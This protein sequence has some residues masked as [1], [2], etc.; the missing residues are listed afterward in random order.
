MIRSELKT[1]ENSRI[2][3]A[4]IVLGVILI[5]QPL[6]SPVLNGQSNYGFA[7]IL[8]RN[9]VEINCTSAMVYWLGSNLSYERFLTAWDYQPMFQKQNMLTAFVGLKMGMGINGAGDSYLFGS[10]NSG[11]NINIALTGGIV[12][13]TILPLV[14]YRVSGFE[15]GVGFYGGSLNEVDQDDAQIW[16]IITWTE[17]LYFKRIYLKCYLGLNPVFGLGIGCHF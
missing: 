2:Q 6:T 9:Q 1:R 12:R 15:L 3:R 5:L 8:N 10:H 17:S 16:P 4:L 11:G 14:Y 7:S 13:E